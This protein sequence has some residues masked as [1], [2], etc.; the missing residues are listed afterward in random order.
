[1]LAKALVLTGL[2][3]RLPEA[4]PDQLAVFADSDQVAPWAV[5]AV[6]DALLAGLVQGRSGDRLAPKATVTR[7][8][9]AV[10]VQRLL[11]KSEL[12]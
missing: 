8:E 5:S 3:D 1:M 10:M 11:Q 2:K 9:V 4:L 6:T 7:A 12:I